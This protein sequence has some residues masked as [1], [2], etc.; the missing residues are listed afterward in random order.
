LPRHATRGRAVSTI[1]PHFLRDH[2]VFATYRGCHGSAGKWE[3]T[4]LKKLM[5][6]AMLLIALVVFANSLLMVGSMTA[7]AA[8]TTRQIDRHSGHSQPGPVFRSFL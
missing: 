8:P 7:Q 3:M 6:Q 5:L 4:M 2:C 1:S